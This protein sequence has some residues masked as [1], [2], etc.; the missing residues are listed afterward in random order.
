MNVTVNSDDN[1]QSS[2]NGSEKDDESD[3][4]EVAEQ[5][6][7]HALAGKSAAD[8]RRLSV[9]TVEE[10]TD[11]KN[12]RFNDSFCTDSSDDSILNNL[13]DDELTEADKALQN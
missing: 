2:D 6:V 13:S 3:E 12:S 1:S 5:F 11:D 8:V 10:E 4:Q 9:A 7:T